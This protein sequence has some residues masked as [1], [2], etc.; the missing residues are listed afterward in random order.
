MDIP[1]KVIEKAKDLI[2]VYGIKIKYIG[3]FE[4]KEVYLFQFP[5]NDRT[6]FPHVYLY[7]KYT[8]TAEE[9]TGVKALKIMRF[10]DY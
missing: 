1:Q 8:E 4:N 5:K 10:I 7:D 2:D 9:I 6:G 3:K